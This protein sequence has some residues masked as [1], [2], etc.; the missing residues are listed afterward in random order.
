MGCCD[1]QVRS[2]KFDCKNRIVAD[3]LDSRPERI[4]AVVEQSLVRM[5]TDYIDLLYQH[6]VDPAV[7]MEEVAGA[8]KDLI[9]AGKVR[10]FGLSEA[11]ADAIRRA[12][13]VQLFPPC[14]KPCAA[15]KS[16]ATATPPPRSGW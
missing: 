4:R 8:V 16:S 14:K 1:C 2:T 7:P 11:G 6:R 9:A 5:N 13:A 15:L 12:H 3:G 10:Y